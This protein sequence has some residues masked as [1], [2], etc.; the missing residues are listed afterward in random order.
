MN[1][2]Y[3]CDARSG[4][5][6]VLLIEAEDHLREALALMLQTNGFEVVACGDA[7]AALDRLRSEP[8]PEV[9]VLDLMLPR[10]D[11][12]RF[13]L[14]QRRHARWSAIPV[15]VLSTDQSA[16]A[17]AI[18]ADAFLLKPVD[19]GQLVASVARLAVEARRKRGGADRG[20]FR[21]LG[22]LASEVV[23]HAEAPLGAALGNLQLAQ[24]KA[25]ELGARLHGPDAFSMIGV[26]QLLERGHR[27]VQRLEAV[28]QGTAAFA[29]LTGEE[30]LRAAPRV[31]LVGIDDRNDSLESEDEYE[32]VHASDAEAI[33]QLR[34]GELF[35]LILCD[36]SAPSLRGVGFHQRLFAV[37]PGQASNVVFVVGDE[38]DAPLRNFLDSTQRPL[39][40]RPF[41]REDLLR[42]VC[43]RNCLLN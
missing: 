1:L 34:A 22:K 23:R 6:L 20:R 43:G 38:I 16:K 13:R 42:F 8:L 17:A 30:L 14:E 28:L 19:A 4:S 31:L 11:G 26:R 9:I 37:A 25:G 21:P 24:I 29:A 27:A 35:E 18:D 5:A 12:W 36:V 10:M 39:L 15:A 32:L 2:S 7:R 41:G 40:R 33:E 3:G